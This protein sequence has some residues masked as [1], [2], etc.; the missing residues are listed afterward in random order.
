MGGVGV[1]GP[2]G[3]GVGEG[4]VFGVVGVTGVGLC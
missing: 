3:W 1:D 2:G 4:R